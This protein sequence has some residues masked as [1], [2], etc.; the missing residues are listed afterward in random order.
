MATCLNNIVGVTDKT[1]IPFYADL[2]PTL[3]TDIATSTSG[4]YMDRLT[5]GID[6]MAV[7]DET[8]MSSVLNLALDA[9]NEAAKILND[10]LLLAINN[11]FKAAKTK[12][13]GFIGRRTVSATSSSTGNI[14]GHR[15]K[16]HEP[17]AGN[18]AISAIAVNVNG[19]ADFN[20][21]I[22]RRDAGNY[23]VNDKGI[24]ETLYTL[25]VTSVIN[26]WAN[27]TLPSGGILLPM[28][29]DGVA[30]EYYIYWKRDESGGLMAKNNDMKCG[31]CGST[32][33]TQALSGFMAYDGISLANT[34]N[35][36]NIS[37]DKLGHGIS[38]SAVVG[39]DNSM[40][41]CREYDKKE[42]VKLMMDKAAQYKAGEL[43]IEYIMKSGYINNTNMQSREMMWGKRN[44]FQKEFNERITA[45]ANAM[46]LGETNCY[47]CKDNIMYKGT[48]FS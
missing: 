40:V 5:G 39:C 28:E 21:Y 37:T 38:V 8:Y 16:M 44:H 18:I 6:L 30:Q 41:I 48:I 42:A 35:V 29:V 9:R 13:I 19:S 4:L 22:G 36:R 3:Q 1:T 25:P 10:E 24:E 14:Q 15:Y 34:D 12:Y 2:D 20:V 17:I 11:R 45:I 26:S 47:V 27:A 43:W 23:L 32:T 31:T 33:A 46:E 7:D